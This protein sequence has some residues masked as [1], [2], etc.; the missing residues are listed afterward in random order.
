[1]ANFFESLLGGWIPWMQVRVVLTGKTPESFLNFLRG[2]FSGE[3]Q[4]FV[5]IVRVLHMT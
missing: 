4:N 3:F 2:G 1:L 5:V